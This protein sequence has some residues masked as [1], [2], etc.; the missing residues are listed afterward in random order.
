MSNNDKE[1]AFLAV[2]DAAVTESKPAMSPI[3]Q[4]LGCPAD[5]CEKMQLLIVTYIL[6]RLARYGF[7]ADANGSLRHRESWAMADAELGSFC[8]E[9]LFDVRQKADVSSCRVQET[10]ETIIDR[11][12]RKRRQEILSKILRKPS[13]KAGEKELRRW[14]RAVTG[15]ELEA[16][17]QVMRHWIWLVKS[18]QSGRKGSAHVMP[19]L[20]GPQGSGKSEATFKF[21]SPWQELADLL[22]EASDLTDERKRPVLASKAAGVLDEL[23]GMA[24][25]DAAELKSII[26]AFEISYRPMRTNKDR[27]LPMAMS[28]IGTSNFALSEII[29]DPSGARR[30]YEIKSLPLCD[31]ATINDID[32]DTLWMAVSED[33]PAPGEVHRELIRAAQVD[34]VWR[35]PVS[36]WLDEERFGRVTL[37][38]SITIPPDSPEVGISTADIYERF[39]NWCQ[40]H[41]EK[42]P[43][44]EHLGRRLT[45]LGWERFRPRINGTRVYSYRCETW[46]S[47]ILSRDGGQDVP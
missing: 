30:F 23:A 4:V 46:D 25:A 21:V 43:S 22:M 1:S 28:F 37:K 47:D 17:V 10:M 3:E 36:R 44:S 8:R 42:Q 2:I 18:K 40:V 12:A 6:A 38:N 19:V 9:I 33:D 29:K 20:T 16:D 15:A 27:T 35:D 7:R 11:E 34:F 32:Y 39:A 5:Q 31:W 14:V 45:D 13:S 26:T 41:G 24:K